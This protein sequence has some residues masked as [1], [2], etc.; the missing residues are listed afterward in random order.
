MSPQLS[1]LLRVARTLSRLV[2]PLTQAASLIVSAVVL[3]GSGLLMTYLL[4]VS[5]LCLQRATFASH[6]RSRHA[7]AM[8][9]A[10]PGDIVNH[11]NQY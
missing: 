4:D 8:L 9:Q 3:G 2:S 6:A 5:M 1:P 10:Q 7:S 11:V